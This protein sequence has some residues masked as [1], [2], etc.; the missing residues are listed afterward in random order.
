MARR[1]FLFLAFPIFLICSSEISRDVPIS[2]IIQSE[3]I[4][5]KSLTIAIDKSDYQLTIFSG[6]KKVKTYSVVFGGNPV[7]DKLMQGDSCTPEGIFKV[8][9]FYPHKSWSKFIWIDYPND[10]SW[11][12]HKNAKEKCLIPVDAKIGGEIGIH[13]V[14]E[15]YDHAIK[16]K[17]NWTLGC[18]SM[19]N[20]DVNEIYPFVFAGMKVE[21]AK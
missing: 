2:E 21:I 18:I 5:P 14:P 19:T 16:M 1:V 8:R 7:D 17:M 4:D 20:E 3:H 10:A 13:G 9:A 15:G 12:K 6:D 11:E